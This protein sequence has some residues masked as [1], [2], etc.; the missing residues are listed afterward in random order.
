MKLA[1]ERMFMLR[2]KTDLDKIRDSKKSLRKS[3]LSANSFFGLFL[4][5]VSVVFGFFFFTSSA[6]EPLGQPPSHP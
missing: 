6:I 2:K 1:R 3:S 5:V 4:F